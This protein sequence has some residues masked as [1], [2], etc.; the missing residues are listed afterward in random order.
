MNQPFHP[1]GTE[2]PDQLRPERDDLEAAVIQL[3]AGIS[4]LGFPSV[5]LND[6]L[7]LLRTVGD[8]KLKLYGPPPLPSEFTG[9]GSGGWM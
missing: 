1:W 6:H 8:V 5:S 7:A 4:G 2:N 3:L 9:C